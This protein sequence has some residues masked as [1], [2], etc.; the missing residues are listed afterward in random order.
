MTTLSPSE[1]FRLRLLVAVML[2]FGSLFTFIAICTNQ[3]ADF[4]SGVY[5]GIWKLCNTQICVSHTDIIHAKVFLVFFVICGILTNAYVIFAVWIGAVDT[6]M[7]IG[8]ASLFNAILGVGGM[9]SAT[10]YIVTLG[11]AQL[12]YGF[13]LGWLGTTLVTVCGIVSLVHSLLEPDKPST[14]I[15]NMT[16]GKIITPPP[17][18]PGTQAAPTSV[19][20][21]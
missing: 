21:S 18:Y 5:L 7:I 16:E 11:P 14:L 20:V 2:T 9:V 4:G 1:S 13:V 15:P 3:W 19:I 8:K 12:L 6:K 17:P 10:V